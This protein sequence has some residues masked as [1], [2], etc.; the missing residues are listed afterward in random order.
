VEQAADVR[1]VEPGE[2]LALAPEAADQLVRV[3]PAL[4]Q[5]DRHLLLVL[6]VGALG[7]IDRSH[8]AAAELRDDPV[9]PE[10]RAGLEARIPREVED[11]GLD[12][13]AELGLEGEHRLDLRAQG[14]VLAAGLRKEGPA[15][16]FR[17]LESDLEKILDSLPAFGCHVVLD[18]VIRESGRRRTCRGG[19]GRLPKYANRQRQTARPQS[20]RGLISFLRKRRA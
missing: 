12:E 5:L 20:S 11:G 18:F 3:E 1:V 13:V 10:P 6:G 14:L 7:E 17:A 2:D 8:A 9:G 16:V 15:L 4:Q 19:P